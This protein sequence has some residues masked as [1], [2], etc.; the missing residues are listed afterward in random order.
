M[1][2]DYNKII[3]MLSMI[4]II[5]IV[6]GVV[7]INPF[8]AKTDTKI[9]V[10]SNDVLYNGDSFSISLTDANGTPLSN[11]KIN[12]IIKDA[13]GNENQKTITTNENGE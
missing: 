10:V 1:N 11:Q 4:I 5:L 2:M 12:I 8:A 6:V 13:N 7:I 9:T 3:V